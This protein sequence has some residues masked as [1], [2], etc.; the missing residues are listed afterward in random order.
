[1]DFS[2][3]PKVVDL[4]KRVMAFVQEH[5]IP[6]EQTFKEEMAAFRAA[7]NP[8]QHTRTMETLKENLKRLGLSAKTV[9]ADLLSF[10]TGERFDAV[11][12]DAPCSATGTI[13]R[14]PDLPWRKD[15]A[16]IAALVKIQAAALDRAASL[17]KPGGLL[18]YATCSLEPEE[19]E[20]QIATFLGGN[21][22]F[23]RAP[24]V[25]SEVGGVAD[26]VTTAGDLRTL[27]CHMALDPSYKSG[28]DG[29]YAARLVRKA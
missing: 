8:W 26:W 1:M 19:G 18:V 13:R 5:V 9:I 17:V 25:A 10:E 23:T 4:Q 3:S 24:I 29:F 27:P 20:R 14:H 2:L 21:A 15:A 7:G 28:M 11:L 6:G 12:L 22:D 16:A